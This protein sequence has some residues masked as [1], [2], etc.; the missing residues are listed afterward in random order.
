MQMVILLLTQVRIA[1]LG[2]GHSWTGFAC[3]G[4]ILVSEATVD[5][6]KE[7]FLKTEGP[8]AKRLVAALDAAQDAG[9]TGGVDNQQRF[10]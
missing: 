6:L 4:N 2:Q 8:L 3:Q 10:S 5:A 9:E 7:T 1:S